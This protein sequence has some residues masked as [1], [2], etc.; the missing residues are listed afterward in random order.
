MRDMDGANDVWARTDAL[1]APAGGTKALADPG[2]IGSGF[3]SQLHFG[4][5]ALRLRAY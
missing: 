2:E 1:K 4:Q 3:G 5:I